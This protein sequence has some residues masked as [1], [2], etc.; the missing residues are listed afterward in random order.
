[1]VAAVRPQVF[2]AVAERIGDHEKFGDD[3]LGRA[4]FSTAAKDAIEKVRE[5]VVATKGVPYTRP[6]IL[7]LGDREPPRRLSWRDVRPII[8]RSSSD[9]PPQED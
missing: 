2:Q 6:S 7:D 9:V 3:R 1:M 4:L 5:D 8:R